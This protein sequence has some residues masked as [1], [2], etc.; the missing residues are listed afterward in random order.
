MTATAS[1]AHTAV[2]PCVFLTDHVFGTKDM[3]CG[4]LLRLHQQDSECMDEEQRESI[5]HRFEKALKSIDPGTRIYQYM[6]KRRIGQVVGGDSKRS[7]YIA[8]KKPF[9][10][11]TYAC[12][13]LSRV[14]EEEIVRMANEF[15]FKLGGRSCATLQDKG[16]IF[17]FL[18]RLLNYNLDVAGAV[19]LKRDM[20]V[21]Y[22]AADS[23]IEAVSSNISIG[24]YHAAALTLKDPPAETFPDLIG[25]LRDTECEF[26][27]VSEWVGMDQQAARSLIT[28]KAKHFHRTKYVPN[29]L[30]DIVRKLPG[31]GSGSSEK[32][33]DMQRDGSAAAA[34]KELSEGLLVAI[35]S[36][37]MLGQFALTVIVLDRSRENVA[38]A[39]WKA[40]TAMS[41]GDGVLILETRN[42]LSAWLAAIPGGHRHQHRSMYLTSRNYADMSFLFEPAHGAPVNAHLNDEYLALMETRQSGIYYA[43][44]HFGEVGHTLISGMTGSGKSFLA[45][46]LMREAI[47]KYNCR[48]VIMD[49]G[50]GFRSLVSDT[51]GAYMEVGLDNDYTI[52]PFCM[53]DQQFLFSFCKVLI[54][55]GQHRMDEIETDKLFRAIP[56]CTRLSDLVVR[57]PESLRPCLARWI[58]EGQYGNL[59][60][61]DT[62]TL[63]YSRVQAFDFEAISKFPQIVEPLLFYILHRMSSE[64]N[65][66]IKELKI[67]L[68]DEAWK[69]LQNETVKQY[70]YEALKTWRKKNAVIVMATQSLGDLVHTEMLSTVA[71]NCGTLILLPNPRLNRDHYRDVFK[72]NEVE[73][74]HVQTMTEKRESLWKPATG[75]SKVLVLDT[76]KQ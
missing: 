27:I 30:G 21:D 57:L 3:E 63:T 26:I 32:T 40:I 25:P 68:L 59:F 17:R 15:I 43:N 13:L 16:M 7:R 46:F 24:D 1:A 62:D 9:R 20:Y 73:L 60:D 72:L 75:A 67:F 76:G 22:Y 70:V 74:D 41:A 50:G 19:G 51:D 31:G 42:A 49:I 56:G 8:D 37:M 36:G 48:L 44:L 28:T 66:N 53:N 18:R 45:N 34:E 55:S 54:E 69:F 6:I 61:N 12:L 4:V 65:Q 5:R 23:G 2:Q 33:E 71:E 38:R 52:N 14:D 35:E 10:I 29:I 58:G 39:A 64:L 11:E 47:R